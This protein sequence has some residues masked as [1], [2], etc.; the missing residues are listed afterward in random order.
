MNDTEVMD[1]HIIFIEDDV[2]Q[3]CVKKQAIL[4]TLEAELAQNELALVTL[5]ANLILFERRYVRIVG[6]LHAKFDELEVK[7]AEFLV[8][9]YPNNQ[10]VAAFSHQAQAHARESSQASFAWDAAQPPF[11]FVNITSDCF[12]PS[13]HLKQY[14]REIAKR[15]HPDLASADEERKFRTALMIEANIAFQAGNELRL[16]EILSQ[17]EQNADMFKGEDSPEMLTRLT[18]RVRRVEERLLSIKDEMDHLLV[19]P[20]YQIYCQVEEAEKHDIDLLAAMAER[21]KDKISRHQERLKAL[22]NT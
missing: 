12:R 2:E 10:R 14:Y 8:T 19:S 16:Q 13:Q 17:W 6:V 9:R 5:R 20:L 7:I 1:M 4:D 18:L 15:I 22:A 3:E 21:L 11:D